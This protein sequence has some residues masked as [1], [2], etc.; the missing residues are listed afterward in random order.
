M[1][2]GDTTRVVILCIRCDGNCVVYTVLDVGLQHPSPRR[3]QRWPDTQV[4]WRGRLHTCFPA[5]L[6]SCFLSR[7]NG[8]R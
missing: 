5:F 4:G 2:D 3:P 6:L 8:G 7:R 1:I